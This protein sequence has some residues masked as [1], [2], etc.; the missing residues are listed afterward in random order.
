MSPSCAQGVLIESSEMQPWPWDLFI[1]DFLQGQREGSVV[2]QLQSFSRS[3][4]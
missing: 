3:R 2:A 4:V 1:K